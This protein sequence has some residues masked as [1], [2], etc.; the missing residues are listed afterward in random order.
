VRVLAL[1]GE[2]TSWLEERDVEVHRGDILSPAT[3]AA[4]FSG[5]DGVFHLAAMIGAWRPMEDYCSVN[6]TGTENVCR[7]ALRADVPRLVHISSAMVYD[8][9]AAR[10]ATEDDLLA[11]LDEPYCLTKALGDVLV[12]RWIREEH[13]PAVIVRPGTLI[14]PGDRLNFGRMADR[15]RRGKGIVIGSGRNTIL[16]F[17]VSDMV[18]GLL[19][20]LESETAEGRVYNLGSDVPITQAEYLSLIAAECGVGAPRVHVPYRALYA[21]AR[22]AERVAV[23]SANR[24]PPLVTRHGVKLYGADNRWSIDKARDELGYE[25]HVRPADAVRAACRWY[26]DGG[27]P[28]PGGSPVLTPGTGG[29]PCNEQ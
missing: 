21:A 28:I 29:R 3:L 25:P 20:A 8:T 24:I 15:I 4:P 13:L 16:V 14:G 26:L 27:G 12:Q 2:D 9:A 23:M 11:P 5:V 18:R 7:A 19:L 6:V 22:M 10:P 1:Q 17:D